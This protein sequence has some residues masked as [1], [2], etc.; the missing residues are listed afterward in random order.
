MG[1]DFKMISKNFPQMIFHFQEQSPFP[2]KG[3][4]I[5]FE[6]IGEIHNNLNNHEKYKD[7]DPVIFGTLENTQILISYIEEIDYIPAL[8]QLIQVRIQDLTPPFYAFNCKF[9]QNII[10]NHLGLQVKFEELQS[11]PY[12][13]K[14]KCVIELGIPGYGDPFNGNGNLCRQAWLDG[15]IQECIKHNRACLLKEAEILKR[16]VNELNNQTFSLERG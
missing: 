2:I 14:E 6:T 3:T 5:D 7:I 8:I 13:K 4:I 11:R 10:K 16:R 15:R 1:R 9:E 12:E